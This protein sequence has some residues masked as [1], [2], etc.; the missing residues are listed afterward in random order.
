ML[1][2]TFV[3]PDCQH[4]GIESL[5]AVSLES[6]CEADF[7]YY[8]A[9]NESIKKRVRSV[10]FMDIAK[11]ILDTKPDIVAFSCI[12]LNYQNQLGC[13][14][15]VKELEQDIIIVFGGIHVTSV[16]GKVIS[17]AEIDAVAIGEAEIPFA[18]FLREIKK[19]DKFA[20]PDKPIEGI[21][22]KK[23][24]R[25]IGE[26]KEGPLSDL[27][28]LPMPHKP[29]FVKLLIKLIGEYSIITS[30]DCP[31]TCSYCCHSV[32]KNMR[33]GKIFRQRKVS[34]IIAELQMAKEKFSPKYIS[35]WD[36]SFT[37]DKKWVREFCQTYKKSKIGL[38]FTCIVTPFYI[39]R[40]IADLLKSSGCA[41]MAMGVQ[42]ISD[43]IC[44]N[45][46]NR[47]FDK[48]KTARAIKSIKEAGIV[49]QVDHIFGI[50]GD[51]REN[52]KESVLFYNKCKPHVINTYWLTYFPGTAIVKIAHQMGILSDLDVAKLEEGKLVENQT[53]LNLGKSGSKKQFYAFITILNYL[54]LLPKWFVKLLMSTKVYR[55]FRIKSYLI[56]NA[57]LHFLVSITRKG[58][59][60]GRA[61]LKRFINEVLLRKIPNG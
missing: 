27:K 14:R 61:Y 10:S 19:N 60:G 21:V 59:Y 38:P 33:G 11:K 26:F 43:E 7:V 8:Q 51:T 35:F 23:D 28:D 22:Y 1:K 31:Y 20:L 2:V 13:A 29:P 5:M 32:I 37:T 58:Y 50:P 48:E 36:D 57:V 6:G 9:N 4:L 54:P 49:V 34:D 15:A 45:V 47:P 17:N 52:Q 42:S 39:T 40:E 12:T 24:G 25:Q 18:E 53:M 41:F 46:L 30:R 16:P 44:K 3:Y 55:A 56:T